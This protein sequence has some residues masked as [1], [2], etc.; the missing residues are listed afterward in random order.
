MARAA[1]EH[2]DDDTQ[3]LLVERLRAAMWVSVVAILGVA[4]IDPVLYPDLAW[5]LLTVLGV[6]LVAVLGALWLVGIVTRPG[7]VLAIALTAVSVL[8]LTTALSGIIVG[9]PVST[10][11]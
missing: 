10:P 4:L 9:D 5:P 3:Q 7:H 8:C 11:V 6:E 1:T 2:H